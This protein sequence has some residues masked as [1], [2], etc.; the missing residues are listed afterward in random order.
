MSLLTTWTF[1]DKGK[2]KNKKKREKKKQEK[3]K[4]KYS[5]DVGLEPTA[6]RL[7]AARSTSWANQA[8]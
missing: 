6:V 4:Q 3:K 2:K 1:D 7:K 8:R 5:P